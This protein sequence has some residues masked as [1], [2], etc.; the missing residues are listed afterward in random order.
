ML[1]KSQSKSKYYALGFALLLVGLDQWFKWL[2]IENIK[3][4]PG[5]TLMLIPGVFHLTY[6]E[7]DSMVFGFLSGLSNEGKTTLMFLLSG[8]TFLILAGLV[9][10]MLTG[11]IKSTFL[12][13]V[14]GAIIGG[15]LGNLIDRVFR[16]SADSGLHYVVD[17]LDLRIINF[18]IFNFADCCVVVGVILVI[19]YLFF[20][21]HKAPKHKAAATDDAGSAAKSDG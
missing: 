21:E 1:K 11:K 17:Y 20:F 19:V 3:S 13:W 8:V 18:A 14:C 12:I 10:A 6:V 16:V 5:R 9:V 2:V 4:L 15:G 7:N